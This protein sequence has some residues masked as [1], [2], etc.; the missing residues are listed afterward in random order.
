[1]Q[2]LQVFF[3]LRVQVRPVKAEQIIEEIEICKDH[4]EELAIVITVFVGDDLTIQLDLAGFG[5][6]QAGDNLCQ[7]RFS[8]AVATHEE[9]EFSR[10]KFE[11]DGPEDEIA[12]LLLDVVGMN[13]I[14][15]LKPL[16]EG[17]R[18]GRGDR[19]L[20]FRMAGQRNSQGLHFPQGYLSA[21]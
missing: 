13:Y 5:Q 1:M 21:A 6:I 12:V 15:K 14:V 2:L 9:D 3:G 17:F 20:L 8:T 10:S 4:G 19:A 18:F 7:R 11:V 16:E